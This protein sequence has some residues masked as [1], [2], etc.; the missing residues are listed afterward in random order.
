[1]ASESEW[2]RISAESA[3]EASAAPSVLTPAQQAT[4]PVA[5]P[6]NVEAE[7]SQVKKQRR[8]QSKTTPAYYERVEDS[9]RDTPGKGSSGSGSASRW[10][11]AG[12]TATPGQASRGF[13]GA[14]PSP[15]AAPER[16]AEKSVNSQGQTIHHSAEELLA[17]Q[18]DNAPDGWQPRRPLEE[19]FRIRTNPIRRTKDGR[20]CRCIR[21]LVDEGILPPVEGYI[22]DEDYF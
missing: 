16:P 18:L 4:A 22:L 10:I 5:E 8:S 20:E 13:A 19:A 14:Y 12:G 11:G 17:Y 9:P 3:L 6:A 15:P 1:M 2:Q 7:Q 21:A